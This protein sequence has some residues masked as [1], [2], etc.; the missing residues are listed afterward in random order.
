M[1][2]QVTVILNDHCIYNILDNFFHDS[3]V[4]TGLM[5]VSIAF[6]FQTSCKMA[7]KDMGMGNIEG[8]FWL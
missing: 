1:E 7:A 6:T 4:I 2:T 8:I 5:C 3:F